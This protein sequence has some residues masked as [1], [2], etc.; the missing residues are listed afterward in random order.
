MKYAHN[1]R[2]MLGFKY[3]TMPPIVK[4]DEEFTTKKHLTIKDEMILRYM[5]LYIYNALK[6]EDIVPISPKDGDNYIC[7]D[8][9]YL[10]NNRGVPCKNGDLIMGL[11]L[12][13][14]YQVM[15]EM[16]TPDGDEYNLFIA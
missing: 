13:P 11:Y 14:Y 15:A 7:G 6:E 5:A 3:N 1:A 9:L 12:G 4:I 16:E 10:N 2:P 8:V